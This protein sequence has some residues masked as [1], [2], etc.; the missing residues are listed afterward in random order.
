MN[1]TLLTAKKFSV[2]R[3][4]YVIPGVG[5]VSRELVVHPGAVLILPLLTP[6]QVV[7]IHNYRFSIGAELLE[8]PAGTLEPGED[9]AD[10]AARELEEETGYVG[11]RIEPLGRFYTSPG[12]TNELMHAFVA[13]GLKATA[14][15]P[16]ATE[17]IRVTTLPLDD[18][19]AATING[20]IV[21][22][23]TIAALHM[24]HY[25]RLRMP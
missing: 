18:A 20:R 16:E 14:P 5:P 8:L 22:G 3:R 25:R 6:D 2:E 11:G 13:T 10:C 23:K 15:R 19:L 12:F 1:Q 9:P 21:D 17:Q 4:E 24:Y 7:M